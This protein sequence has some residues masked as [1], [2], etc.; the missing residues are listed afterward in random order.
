MPSINLLNARPA[1]RG[2]ILL[3]TFVPIVVM[4][5]LVS[6]G[7]L[8]SDESVVWVHDSPERGGSCLQNAGD[9]VPAILS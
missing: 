5:L 6:G 7:I 2:L 9:C 1:P 8:T 4:G 3:E